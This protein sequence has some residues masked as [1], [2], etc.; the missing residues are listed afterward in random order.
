MNWTV[1]KVGDVLNIPM[2]HSGLTDNAYL[3]LYVRKAC[4][5]LFEFLNMPTA[6]VKMVNGCPGVGKSVEVFSYA[7]DQAQLHRK[8]VLYVHGNIKNG[9]T[10]LF[11]DDPDVSTARVGGQLNFIS[12]PQE[13]KQIVVTLLAEGSVDLIVLDGSLSWLILGIYFKMDEHPEVLLIVCTSFQA[14]GKLSQEVSMKSAVRETFVMES[15]THS[16]LEIAVNKAAL[17]LA[18][19]TTVNEM[20]FYAGGSARLFLKPVKTVVEYLRA[21]IRQTPDMG[22]LIGTRGVGD[23]SADATNSL[24]AIY[25][26]ESIILS[27]FVTRELIQSV[28]DD[29]IQKARTF[30]PDNPAWQGWVT[31]AEVMYFARTKLNMIFRNDTQNPKS[32]ET[33]SSEKLMV[34]SFT[35]ATDKALQS[36]RIGWYQPE[37][38]NEKGF[39]CLFRVSN[40][41]LRVIQITD[42]C[43]TRTFDLSVVIPLAKAMKV[44]VIEVVHL[45]RKMNFKSLKVTEI[46][47]GA[48]REALM[49]VLHE[50]YDA[51]VGNKKGH[52]ESGS[53]SVPEPNITFRTLCYQLEE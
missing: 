25:D 45:S 28:S 41:C 47:V 17:V 9:F 37:K 2:S 48:P 23:S 31:E 11:K 27:Q 13:L 10:I 19:G 35:N 50:I 44:Q 24:M 38:Y 7:M 33:W 49:T 22:K 3:K 4:L 14:I 42:T 30:L 6:N 51:K 21:K 15:W 1:A 53:E 12:E 43:Y 36:Q 39:D 8:R 52:M 29:F 26:G 40:H 34:T 32:V 18:P 46:T 5:D 16:E 20:F